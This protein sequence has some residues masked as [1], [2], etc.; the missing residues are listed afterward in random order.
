LLLLFL[1]FLPKRIF[2]ASVLPLGFRLEI[3]PAVA[4]RMST[5][6]IGR[7]PKEARRVIPIGI[8]WR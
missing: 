5:L 6:R 3:V 2:Y 8:F 7:N 1:L 4:E